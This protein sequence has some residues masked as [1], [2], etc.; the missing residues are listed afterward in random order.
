[1]EKHLFILFGLRIEEETKKYVKHK[2]KRMVFKKRKT[3]RKTK[4]KQ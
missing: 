3:K 1:M 2:W 4:N